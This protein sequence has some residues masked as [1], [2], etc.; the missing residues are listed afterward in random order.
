MESNLALNQI[1]FFQKNEIDWNQGFL[2]SKEMVS[3]P[4]GRFHQKRKI[5]KRVTTL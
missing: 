3:R 4:D 2:K 5:E 1:D